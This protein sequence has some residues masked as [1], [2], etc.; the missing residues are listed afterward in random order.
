M[1]PENQM[2]VSGSDRMGGCHAPGF[3]L[4][5]LLFLAGCAAPPYVYHYIPGRT[6]TMCNGFAI[7]PPAAPA[8]VQI[9]IAAGNRITGLPYE[10]GA[11][12]TSAEFDRAYDCS[13][14]ASFVLRAAGLLDS[15]TT[16]R[17]FR[18][19]GEA[20]AGRWITLYARRGHVFMVVAGLRFDTGWTG[21]RKGPQWTE[22]SRPSDGA[23]MRHPE[24]L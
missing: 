17:A 4:L 19:Y 6:A 18:H 13:G 7:A 1:N 24:G 3:V 22:R 5:V 14:A 15:P 12:H 11:G 9:A 8:D 10:Y 21:G 20:G 16:S 23:V 2:A